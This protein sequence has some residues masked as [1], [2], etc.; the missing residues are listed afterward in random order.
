MST[1]S[2]FAPL[3]LCLRSV[4]KKCRAFD[5]SSFINSSSGSRLFWQ[6]IISERFCASVYRGNWLM[7]GSGPKKNVSVRFPGILSEDMS[8]FTLVWGDTGSS[9][10]IVTLF[11]P[12]PCRHTLP[13]DI[14][15]MFFH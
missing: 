6:R 11:I 4:G 12:L 3:F 10:E 1:G 2:I 13:F 9:G 7:R 14:F 5:P 15:T 8:P